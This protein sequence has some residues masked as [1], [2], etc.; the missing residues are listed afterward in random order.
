M[1]PVFASEKYSESV[2]SIG[3]IIVKNELETFSNYWPHC[4]SVTP[5]RRYAFQ[6]ADIL[7]VWVRTIGRAQ[8]IMPLFVAVL[9]RAG[10]PLLFLPLGIE[11]R[12]GAKILRFLDGHVSDFNAP[13]VFPSARDWDEAKVRTLWR[14]LQRQLPGFDLALFEEVTEM[15]EDWPNPIRF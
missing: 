14:E 5:A 7:N 6:C 2:S 15:V 11:Q 4:D 8:K 9:D 10:A 12:Y 3:R 1:P 13:I